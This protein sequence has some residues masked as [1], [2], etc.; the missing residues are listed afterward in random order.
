MDYLSTSCPISFPPKQSLDRPVD[1]R[2]TCI[3]CFRVLL[4]I[5]LKR[6]GSDFFFSF[7]K[8]VNIFGN[9]LTQCSTKITK[10]EI[11]TIRFIEMQIFSQI[12]QSA[13][14]PPW[15]WAWPF[16]PPRTH[17]SQKLLSK[18]FKKTIGC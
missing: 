5:R 15:G 7:H 16:G 8:N 9:S 17:I 4:V 3:Y 18:M 14:L 10:S 13:N 2:L 1:K 12:V 11:G 6:G